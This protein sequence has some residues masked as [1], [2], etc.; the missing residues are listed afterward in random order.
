MNIDDDD[1]DDDF[2][3]GVYAVPPSPG[4]PKIK[5][6]KLSDYCKARGIKP[7]D[8][9]EE[10]LKEFISERS[11]DGR[12]DSRTKRDSI[13]CRCGKTKVFQIDTVEHFVLERKILLHH[14]PHWYCRS[15]KEVTYN[16]DT[17]IT[18]LLKVV[19][20]LQLKAI[21]WQDREKLTVVFNFNADDGLRQDIQS[22]INENIDNI[23]DGESFAII[24]GSRV[25]VGQRMENIIAVQK[26]IEKVF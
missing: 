12:Y 16:I 2:P 10:E 23:K 9:I 21:D 17:E 4:E 3:D 7:S 15:C 6:R 26:I 18:P 25:I 22:I 5:V 1:W 13:D 11:D 20:R 8:L 19:Y 14:V 24:H